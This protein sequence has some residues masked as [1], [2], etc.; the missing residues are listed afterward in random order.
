[1]IVERDWITKSG[2][3]AVC[4]PVDVGRHRVGYVA[5]DKTHPLFKI[6]Y[7][8]ETPKLASLCTADAKCGKKSPTL[9]FIIALSD[10]IPMEPQVAFDVHGGITFSGSGDDY[11]VPS[12]GLW[13]YGFDC[14]H[15]DDTPETCTQEYVESEC[16]RLAQQLASFAEEY[17]EC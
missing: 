4:G 9:L 11:P 8:E 15:L 12:P 10:H 5:I 14:A 13:W 16:E 1:M 17:R 6:G 3:R 2:L 7:N